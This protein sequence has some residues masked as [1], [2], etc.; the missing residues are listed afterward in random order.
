MR[1]GRAA[2]AAGMLVRIRDTHYANNFSDC[3][4][5]GG[6]PPR[7][8]YLLRCAQRLRAATN[9]IYRESTQL[10]RLLQ[11]RSEYNNEE[12]LS[13]G[14]K[15]LGVTTNYPVE[16]ARECFY[17]SLFLPSCLPPS[18][19]LSL[20]KRSIAVTTFRMPM[21]TGRLPVA[22]FAQ[23]HFYAPFALRK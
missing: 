22:V 2:A 3:A 14:T 12:T 6:S 20:R 10:R 23:G 18:L 1:K 9:G 19:P 5:R 7:E 11:P 21:Y 17:L 15:T 4:T 8:R 16:A 13:R